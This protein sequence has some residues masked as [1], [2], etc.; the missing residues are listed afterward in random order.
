L[1]SSGSGQSTCTV[2]RYRSPAFS[3]TRRD[4]VFTAMVVATTSSAP[5][6]VNASRTS[7]RAPS[8]ANPRPQA[9]RRSR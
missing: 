7:A 6:L 5:R 2:R 1:P 8:V 9:L 3:I 4:A